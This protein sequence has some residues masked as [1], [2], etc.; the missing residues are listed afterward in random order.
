MSG[1]AP[2]LADRLH[3]LLV[4][5]GG[6]RTQFARAYQRARRLAARVGCDEAEAV[7]RVAVE[8]AETGEGE[9]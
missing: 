7:R 8:L 4:V 1:P 5:V 3:S 9:G 6:D 2:T